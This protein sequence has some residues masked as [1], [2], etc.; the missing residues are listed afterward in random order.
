MA[1]ILPPDDDEPVLPES[2]SKAPSPL[3]F[4]DYRYYWL[5]RFTAVMATIAMVVVIGYQLYDTART[6]Y[7]M[8]IK[9]ASFQLGLLGLF[10]FVPLAVL[11]PV[12]GWVADRF[13]RRSVAIFSN[14]IDLLIAAA[15][16]W[17]TYTDGLTLP[18]LFGLAAL[19]GVARVFSGPAMSAIAPNIVPPAVLPRAIAM[20]SIAWQSASVIGPAAGG[21]I[22]AAH[23]TSVYIFAAVLLAISAFTISRVRPVLP[24]PTEVRRHPLREM[25]DG[26]QFTWRE[27]FLLGTITL[28]LFAVILS[29]ATAML[30]VYARDILMTGSEGLGF[31]RAAP[32]VGA[33][34]VALGLAWRPIERNVGVKMLWAVV[35]FGLATMAFGLST[36]FLLSLAMLALL[37][38]ADM[39]SVFVRGTLIQLNTPDHMRGRVSA[40][41]GLA[42]SA[43]NELG[44]MRAGS[45]AAAFGPVFAVVA[46]GAAAVGV[47]ALWAW[48][49]PELRRAR[50]FEP[51]FK[52]AE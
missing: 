23:P 9:E 21:L 49:F 1:T 50:T 5:A 31:L 51:Q 48:L 14:L 34:L 22:Y 13:E 33:A 36:N 41:S 39:F 4:P 18:L 15:L 45:M 8:S 42:I 25:A 10:Q 16:G 44:E 38:A 29:G 32:A 2:P 47:T 27:R 52:K 46:G 3:S 40:V 19:H 37:G 28:D 17:F 12:A 43:S 7:G 24:P 20:S 30:P 35:V 26:L 6:D 11:T